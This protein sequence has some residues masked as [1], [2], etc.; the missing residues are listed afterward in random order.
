MHIR[1]QRARP[2]NDRPMVV[3]PSPKPHSKTW[4]GAALA[5]GKK[6][7]GS[8]SPPPSRQLRCRLRFWW[9]ARVQTSGLHWAFSAYK[10]GNPGESGRSTAYCTSGRHGYARLQA[11]APLPFDMTAP[12]GKKKEKEEGWAG[13]HTS[14]P[15]CDSLVKKIHS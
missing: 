6:P 2:T 10:Y 3:V 13:R 8:S 14:D 5:A 11:S 9:R 7:T 12:E 15:P 1:T 4:S